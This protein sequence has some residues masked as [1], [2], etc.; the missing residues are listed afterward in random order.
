[1]TLHHW[2]ATYRGVVV[3]LLPPGAAR[4]VLSAQ[5]RAVA[6]GAAVEGER[7]DPGAW[8][9]GDSLPPLHLW[10]ELV[11]AAGLGLRWADLSGD[12][13]AERKARRDRR[14]G[15]RVLTRADV[16]ATWGLPAREAGEQLGVRRQAVEAA[17]KRWP[18]QEVSDDRS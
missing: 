10:K 17:R 13:Q 8:W 14:A 15:G 6:T 9:R 5:V 11:L 16:L 1:M 7:I 12:W 4:K 3:A 2:R 18:Y